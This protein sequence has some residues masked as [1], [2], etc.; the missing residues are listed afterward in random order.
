MTT[1]R[2]AVVTT[3]K[4]E[5]VE[6]YL[7]SNYKVVGHDADTTTIEGT[8]VAGWTLDGYVIPKLASGLYGC[9][10]SGAV[11]HYDGEGPECPNTAHRVPDTQRDSE[12]YLY[13]MDDEWGARRLTECCHAAV[14][15]HDTTLCCKCCWLEVGYQFVLDPTFDNG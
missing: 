10:E 5:T 11:R 13:V 8:D 6:R 9:R 15:Y 1:T 3:G 2:R 7:P 4:W 12:G 14:T